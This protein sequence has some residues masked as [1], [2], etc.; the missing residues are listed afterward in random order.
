V[1]ILADQGFKHVSA[2][3][4]SQRRHLLAKKIK[5]CYGTIF[6]QILFPQTNLC[7]RPNSKS[8]LILDPD[9]YASSLVTV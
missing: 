7:D 5:N 2:L 3:F 1:H 8:K 4:V 6:S 9:N